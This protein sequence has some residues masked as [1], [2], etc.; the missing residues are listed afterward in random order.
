MVYA[1]LHAYPG[2]TH[3]AL[4]AA[5]ASLDIRVDGDMGGAIWAEA[6]RAHAALA[7]RRRSS[8]TAV[9]R[10][11][12]ADHL[13]GAHAQERADALLTRNA[14]D[15]SDFPALTVIPA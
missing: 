4:D 6:G 3:A 15:F 14:R 8:I 10:R 13:I 1:E 7:A 12:L 11:P 2:M 5:L 9:P